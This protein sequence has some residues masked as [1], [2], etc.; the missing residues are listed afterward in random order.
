MVVRWSGPSQDRHATVVRLRLWLLTR[1]FTLYGEHVTEEEFI[2]MAKTELVAT[3]NQV[4][5]ANLPQDDLG[6]ILQELIRYHGDVE[7]A[8]GVIANALDFD[9]AKARINSLKIANA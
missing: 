2:R 3:P 4:G 5:G 6:S 9:E 8:K 1:G 7:K